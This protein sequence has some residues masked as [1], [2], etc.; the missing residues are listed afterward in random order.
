MKGGIYG[1]QDSSNDCPSFC[2]SFGSHHTQATFTSLL[3]SFLF[4]KSYMNNGR[5]RKS[6]AQDFPFARQLHLV[7]HECGGVELSGKSV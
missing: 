1:K 7:I 2:L 6:R 3:L 5:E 4:D